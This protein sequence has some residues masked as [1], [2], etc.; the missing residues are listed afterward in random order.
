MENTT[1]PIDARLANRLM[2]HLK[3]TWVTPNHLTTLRLLFG[4]LACIGLSTGNYLYS[5]LGALC[6]VISSFLDHC[7]GELARL[8]GKMSQSGH[9]YDLISDAMTN[10]LLFLGIGLGLMHSQLGIWAGV[11]G[12]I[13]GCAVAVI[14]HL[15]HQ[16]EQQ[17]GHEDARQPNVGIIEAEDVLYLLPIVTLFDVLYWFLLL[18][19]YWSTIICLLG[20]L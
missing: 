18:C 7:D 20:N 1:Q 4:I 8:T 12:G 5:N 17:V 2:I 13:A 6:F 11:L 3:A 9:Y 16:I 15:R 10:I 14:F 19:L